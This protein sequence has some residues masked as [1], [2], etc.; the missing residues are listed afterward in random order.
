MNDDRIS[1]VRCLQVANFHIF[2]NIN[3]YSSSEE[4]MKKNYWEKNVEK[5]N[6]EK[7]ILTFLKLCIEEGMSDTM[8]SV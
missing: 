5:K 3:Y 1:C 4:N 2:K 8:I 6:I 7:K